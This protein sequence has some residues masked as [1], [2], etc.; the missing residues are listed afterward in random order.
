MTDG[1][2]Y[3]SLTTKP[4]FQGSGYYL[5]GQGL[6]VS[7][8]GDTSLN[9]TYRLV[10]EYNSNEDFVGYV[11]GP[12]GSSIHYAKVVDGVR[13]WSVVIGK[14]TGAW[15]LGEMGLINTDISTNTAPTSGW[16]DYCPNMDDSCPS[17]T[18]SVSEVSFS[19]LI[20]DYLF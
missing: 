8:S 10:K 20:L 1:I 3:S 4:G 12:D 14:H 9:G 18:A 5:S 15:Q 6:T 11:T 16:R 13:E 2:I 19:D 7:G 17:A